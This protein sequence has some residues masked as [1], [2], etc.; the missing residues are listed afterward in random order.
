[1]VCILAPLHSPISILGVGIEFFPN[2]YVCACQLKVMH[3]IQIGA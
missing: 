3:S 2:F 1:M